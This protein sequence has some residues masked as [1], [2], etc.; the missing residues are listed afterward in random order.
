VRVLH[1][2][3]AFY[4]SIIMNTNPNLK[5]KQIEM[6]HFRVVIYYYGYDGAAPIAVLFLE[7]SILAR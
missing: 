2:G 4:E 6:A 1:D 3:F 5:K 7:S